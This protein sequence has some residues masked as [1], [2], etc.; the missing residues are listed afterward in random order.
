MTTTPTPNDPSP[1]WPADTASYQR[2]E[3]AR[4]GTNGLAIASLVLGIVW[5]FGLGSLLALIFGL[6][7]IKQIDRTGEGGKGMAIAGAILGAVGIIGAAT[8]LGLSAAAVNE[9]D[10]EIDRQVNVCGPLLDDW[11][12]APVG[13]AAEDR[14][15]TAYEDAGCGEL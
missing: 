15:E 5:L 9:V 7:A 4:V 6:I 1:S 12:E 11:A 2:W 10:N 14:A 13:S 8:V 3:P